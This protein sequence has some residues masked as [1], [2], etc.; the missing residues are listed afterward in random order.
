MINI[1]N[2]FAIFYNNNIDTFSSSKEHDSKHD[3]FFI[4]PFKW[5]RQFAEEKGSSKGTPAEDRN[6]KKATYDFKEAI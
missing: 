2:L 3:W 4:G 6:L 1:K 5:S